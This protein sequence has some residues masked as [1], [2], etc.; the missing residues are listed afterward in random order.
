VP[1][2]LAQDIHNILQVVDGGDPAILKKMTNVGCANSV[3]STVLR[4]R[5]AA[6]PR[7]DSLPTTCSCA[8]ELKILKESVATLQANL[9]LIKHDLI[10]NEQL[11]ENLVEASK[12]A[13]VDIKRTVLDCSKSVSATSASTFKSMQNITCSLVQ[14]R[15]EFEDRLRVVE[16]Q[17][18]PDSPHRNHIYDYSCVHTADEYQSDSQCDQQ[19]IT[20]IACSDVTRVANNSTISHQRTPTPGNVIPVRITTRAEQYDDGKGE[21]SIYKRNRT[22]HFCVLGLSRNLNTDLLEK[23]IT[24]K[25]PS[26]TNMRVFPSRR[27]TNKMILKLTISMT[28]YSRKTSGRVT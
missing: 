9:L 1:E 3:R 21:F 15:T 28:V 16:V 13:T 23:D 19:T 2:R 27:N 4:R 8:S 18:S 25:G 5:S 17:S 6:T 20:A 26:V 12:A 14:R 10:V 7:Q 22:K 24:S 11:H